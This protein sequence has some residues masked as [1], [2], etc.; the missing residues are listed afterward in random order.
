MEG[1][2]TPAPAD[3][4][5]AARIRAGNSSAEEEL[6]SLFYQRTYWMA[7]ARIRDREIACDLAQDAIMAV[8]M[9]F[10]EGKLRDPDKLSQFGAGTSRNIINGYL[11]TL[12]RRKETGL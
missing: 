2:P 3:T 7:C 11:R 10:R 5:L 12:Q 1:S 8:I 9:A 4:S 6:V